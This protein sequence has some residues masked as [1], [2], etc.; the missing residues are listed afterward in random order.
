MLVSNGQS[1]RR[2]HPRPA[3]EHRWPSCTVT[4]LEAGVWS[5]LSVPVALEGEAEAVL[6]LHST[7]FLGFSAEDIDTVGAC[8]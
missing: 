8:A 7:R 1:S 6:N 3:T 2:T 4:A 5:R